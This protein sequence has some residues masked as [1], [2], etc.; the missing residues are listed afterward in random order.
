LNE[1][2][3]NEELKKAIDNLWAYSQGWKKDIYKRDEFNTIYP[4]SNTFSWQI[5]ERE[6]Y[7]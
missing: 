3:I 4:T 7:K 2:E 1:S 6:F 5:K